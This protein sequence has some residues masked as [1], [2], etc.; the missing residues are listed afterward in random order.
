MAEAS[1]PSPNHNTRAVTDAEYEQMAAHFSGDG[2]YGDPTNTAAVSAG[3]GLQVVVRANL[4]ASVRGHYWT[5]GTTDLTLPVASNSSGQQ[6][7][8][9][10]VLRLDRST[11]DVTAALH[12]GTPGSGLPALTKNSGSTGVWEIPLGYLQLDSGASTVTVVP[13]TQYVGTR[14]RPATSITHTTA[15]LGALLYETDTGRWVGWNGSSWATIYED[16][17]ELALSPGFDTWDSSA[18]DSVGRRIGDVVT[19]RISRKRVNS[20]LL[21]N[22]P[23]GSKL[24]TIPSTLRPLSRWHFASVT[25]GNKATGRVEVRADGEVWVTYLSADIPV[26]TICVLSMTYVRW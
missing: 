6:R 22:D 20:P 24:V 1:W 25:F 7:K 15:G 5:S 3:V 16:T 19:L 11:W 8:D 21:R 13:Y 23:D 4:E 26:G 12:Q 17:G 10:I 2:V 18:G 9:V 14:I